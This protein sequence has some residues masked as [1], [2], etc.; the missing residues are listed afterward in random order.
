MADVCV[1]GDFC[2]KVYID[3][4]NELQYINSDKTITIDY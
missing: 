2:I 4:I 1:G 3:F